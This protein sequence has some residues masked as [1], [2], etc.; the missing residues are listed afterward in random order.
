MIHDHLLGPFPEEACSS[1]F[2]IHT[3]QIEN[4]LRVQIGHWHGNS[5]EIFKGMVGISSGSYKVLL[6]ELD[7]ELDFEEKV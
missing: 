2:D 6:F 3:T 7:Q 1:G 5:V 4:G